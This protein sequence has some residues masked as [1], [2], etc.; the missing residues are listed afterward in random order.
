[1]QGKPLVITALNE[2]L[3][4]ELTASQQYL[5]GGARFRHAGFNKLATKLEAESKGEFEHARLVA[6]RVLF[7]E[8]IPSNTPLAEP[9]VHNAPVE[10]LKADMALEQ[11]HA[12]RVNAAIRVCRENGDNGSA[13]LLEQILVSTEEHVDW[14]ETQLD[15][16]NAIGVQLYLSQQL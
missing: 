16:S 15:L 2:V 7:L 5:L 11:A 6:Q 3:R 4:A 8:G 13:D 12:D 14:L 10:Q 9:S 1:M